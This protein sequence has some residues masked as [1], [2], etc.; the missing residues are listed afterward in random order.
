MLPVYL[1]SKI[2]GHKWIYHNHDIS[3]SPNKLGFNYFLKWFEKWSAPRADMISFP[4]EDRAIYFK[5]LAKLKN[6][7]IIIFNSPRL[8]WLNINKIHVDL[9]K[10][11][12]HKIILYQGDLNWNRGLDKVISSMKYWEKNWI[13]CLVGNTDLAPGFKKEAN[14]LA[15]SM[16][17]NCNLLIFDPLSYYTLP[18]ITQYCHIGLAVMLGERDNEN[19]NI[20]YLGGASNKIAEYMASGLPIIAPFSNSYSKIFSEYDC[21][22]MLKEIDGISIA[23]AIESLL[24]NKEHY[25]HK[26]NESYRGFKNKYNYDKQFNILMDKFDKN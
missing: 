2:F 23:R 11:P 4:Q 12:N 1:S 22:I 7:P 9:E 10:Y 16:N 20:K 21:G 24:A 25:I 6:M 5:K 26:S 13:L 19:I 14:D 15:K 8:N 17:S 3:I 18:S